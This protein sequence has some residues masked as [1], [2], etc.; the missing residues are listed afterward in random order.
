[1]TVSETCQTFHHSAN[2]T[3]QLLKF[4]EK[5]NFCSVL[6]NMVS[7]FQQKQFEFST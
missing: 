1:M 2:R 6:R 4:R 5:S 3:K 7:F